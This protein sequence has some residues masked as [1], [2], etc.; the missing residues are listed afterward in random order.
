MAVI[1]PIADAQTYDAGTAAR[2][3]EQ[4]VEH[5]PEPP[6]SGPINLPQLIDP[7]L[8]LEDGETLRVRRFVVKGG[9]GLVD[10]A[11]VRGLLKPYEGRKLTLTQIY[12][13]ADRVTG[14]YREAGYLV[15]KAYV[16]EQDASGGTL[17][18]KMVPGAYGQVT[19]DNRS[20]VHSW[21]VQGILERH[22]VR[23][24]ALVRKEGLERA[25]L[26][27]SDLNG[28]GM[29]RSV[30]GAG[31]AQ[32]SSDFLF[33]VPEEKRV[34]GFI[35]GDNFGSPYT[36]RHRA[37]A[38][39]NVNSLLGLGDRLSAF[40]MVS[41]T[42]DLINWRFAY[43]VPL[44]Y[45]GVKAEA[46]IFRT[47]YALGGTFANTQSTGV[48]EGA[49]GTL[50]Y[51]LVRSR[52][53]TIIVSA[54]YTYKR[55]DDQV[56]DTSINE[57]N[58]GAGIATI[59]RQR[60]GEL[61][62]LPYVSS[63]NLG[64]T[65]GNVDYPDPLQL[66]WNQAGADTAGNFR[67]LAGGVTVTMALSEKLSFIV[68]ARGQKSLS[69]NLDSS[70][71]LGLTGVYGVRSYNEGLSGDTGW[72]ITP[73]LKYALPAIGDWNHAVSAF[74]DVGGVSLEDGSY[75]TTQPDYVS[76]A[77][78]GL[79]YYGTY[80]YMSGRMLLLKAYL[81]HTVGADADAASYD[82]GTVGLVQA[83]ITY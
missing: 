82:R 83:G 30:M 61:F 38:G 76:L 41:E 4:A 18:L 80:E 34:D 79:G 69:G 58:L 7:P 19:I 11:V 51:P 48:A 24:G 14:L 8:T 23:N 1:A 32:G 16:P 49:S 5:A 35:L 37:M 26:L 52:D 50:S 75:T 62:G 42:T 40:G 31:R 64:L 70:E 2:E 67:K 44:G 65:I 10:A 60:V 25:M 78:I 13:A 9:E 68:D 72:L 39:V 33:E 59:N 66:A 29:P 81:A 36:G 21:Y 73:K 43:A 55:L 57:R 20:L 63:A 71:Q 3:A 46:A 54:G 12:E 28:A 47:T 53:E 77:D 56:F 27:M 15:A 74:A 6:R 45:D 17:R 22:G